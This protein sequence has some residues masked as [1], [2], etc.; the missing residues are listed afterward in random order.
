MYLQDSSVLLQ[1]VF[2]R[3][4]FVIICTNG[5]CFF[6][7]YGIHKIHFYHVVSI[8]FIKQFSEIIL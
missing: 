4:N 3:L 8:I 2:I 7:V 6:S 1:T 5:R